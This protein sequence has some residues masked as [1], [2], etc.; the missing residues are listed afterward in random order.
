M[1]TLNYLKKMRL[2]QV[3]EGIL[4]FFVVILGTVICG[5]ISLFETK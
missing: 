5:I 1:K 2:W 3:L 4:V